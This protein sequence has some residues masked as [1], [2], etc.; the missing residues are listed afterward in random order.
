M[1]PDLADSLQK[2]YDEDLKLVRDYLKNKVENT[3][4][5]KKAPPQRK[6]VPHVIPSSVRNQARE[7]QDDTTTSTFDQ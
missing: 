2:Q 4:K 6:F 1:L 5:S 7:K 3:D